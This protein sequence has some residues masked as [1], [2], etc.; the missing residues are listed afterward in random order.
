MLK[1]A[2]LVVVIHTLILRL[3]LNFVLVGSMEAKLV[4]IFIVK[5]AVSPRHACGWN[6]KSIHDHRQYRKHQYTI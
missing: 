4:F 5:L 6:K 2:L 1:C 3:S